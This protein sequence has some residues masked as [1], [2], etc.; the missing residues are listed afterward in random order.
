MRHLA[1]GLLIGS[2]EEAD[3]ATFGVSFLE[4]PD[5]AAVFIGAGGCAMVPTQEIAVEVL[6]LL[7]T[8]QG[9]ID[10][11]LQPPTHISLPGESGCWAT[12]P[13]QRPPIRCGRHR[14]A[15]G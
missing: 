5:E 6:R 14:G 1:P 13:S 7:G 10:R 15:R 2:T 11:L 4:D 9:Q 8:E 12:W 3:G